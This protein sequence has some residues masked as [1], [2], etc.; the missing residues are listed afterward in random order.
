MTKEIIRNLMKEKL[1]LIDEQNFIKMSSLISKNLAQLN[2]SLN[3]IQDKIIIGAFA[4]IA[5]EPIWLQS[6]T[7]E[8]QE[9][10]ESL[11]A[12]P[13]AEAN[14]DA[15]I[16]IM[17]KRSDLVIKKDFGFKILGPTSKLSEVNPEV[18]PGVILIPGLAF[19]EKGERLGRGKGFYDKYLNNY[20]G[21]K[22]GICFS[23]QLVE[24][25]PVEKHDV[26]LDYIVTEKKVINCKCI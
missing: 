7:I 21:I 9:V 20:Q 15:M 18:V 11:T 8:M 24:T 13:A 14:K 23:M 5:R 12:Y 4:P 1:S 6:L 22:I 3:I 25:L 10:F 2:S 17:A 26:N 19:T 16:F